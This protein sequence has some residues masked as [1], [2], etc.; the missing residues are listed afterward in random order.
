MICKNESDPTHNRKPGKKWHA[1]IICKN[2]FSQMPMHICIKVVLRIAKYYKRLPYCFAAR[3]TVKGDCKQARKEPGAPLEAREL[4]YIKH[5]CMCQIHDIMQLC[6]KGDCKQRARGCLSKQAARARSHRKK[7]AAA[8]SKFSAAQRFLVAEERI[9][10][11]TDRWTRRLSTV[12]NDYFKAQTAISQS[13]A[14]CK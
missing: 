11:E 14:L 2:I 1:T 10:G 9:G 3:S 13:T 12:G 8:R 4:Y 7:T 6:P 5:R